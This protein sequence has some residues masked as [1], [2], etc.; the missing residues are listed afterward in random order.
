MTTSSYAPIAE[1]T[2]DS[3]EFI[4]VD[5]AAQL[6][7]HP[8]VVILDLVRRGWISTKAAPGG[9]GVRVD[10]EDITDRLGYDRLDGCAAATPLLT[11]WNMSRYI[12]T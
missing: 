9:W 3:D 10:R 2:A 6:S 12:I 7:G 5:T 8:S 1:D 11:D 4:A